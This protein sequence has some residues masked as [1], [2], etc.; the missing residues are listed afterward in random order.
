MELPVKIN[1]KRSALAARQHVHE[2]GDFAALLGGVA[3]FDR[4][5]DAMRHVIAQ[6]FLFHA[7]ERRPHRR[8]L[9]DDV[10]AVALLV[11]HAREASHLPLDAAQA[12]AAG[13][14]AGF[15]HR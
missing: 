9:R 3:A 10:D 7:T 15:L 14:L 13:R 6:D 11:D 12:L 4:V 5:L 1:R 8:D 2:L